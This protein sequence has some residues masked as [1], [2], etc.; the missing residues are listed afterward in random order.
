MTT[1]ASRRRFMQGA[2]A[3]AAAAAIGAPAIAQAQQVTKWRCQSMWS[4]AE[5]TY[6]VFEDF[7]A[8]I[9]KLTNGRLEIEPS[10]G[11]TTVRAVVPMTGE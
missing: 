9:K 7:C 3:G 10:A 5:L 2:T 8:R 11:G 4:S 6:K 1:Q